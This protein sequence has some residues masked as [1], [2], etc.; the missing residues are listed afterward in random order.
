MKQHFIER[1]LHP[2]SPVPIKGMKADLQFHTLKAGDQV[3]L[4]DVTIQTGSL[5]HPNTAIGYRVTWNGTQRRLLFR[6]RTFPRGVGSKCSQ[7]GP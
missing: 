4:E 3:M 5:N 1:V 6:Y 2:N 7:P